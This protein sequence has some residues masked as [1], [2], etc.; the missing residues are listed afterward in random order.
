MIWEE[1][2]HGARASQRVPCKRQR[3]SLQQL[4]HQDRPAIPIKRPM[5]GFSQ[6][7]HSKHSSVAAARTGVD[8]MWLNCG[9]RWWVF[10]LQRLRPYSTVRWAAHA[11]A[12]T[13]AHQTELQAWPLT[14]AKKLFPASFRL[15]NPSAHLE[16]NELWLLSTIT[17]CDDLRLLLQRAWQSLKIR[18]W[19]SG[20]WYSQVHFGFQLDAAKKKKNQTDFLS[21]NN[22][23]VSERCNSSSCQQALGW[24]ISESVS[25]EV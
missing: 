14:S 23:Q 18:I 1:L 20:H 3:W 11:A 15:N 9:T 5:W 8:E 19:K 17:W 24:T 22:K 25:L 16:N 10:P 13:V 12:A 7:K 4:P 21:M 6:T 2:S